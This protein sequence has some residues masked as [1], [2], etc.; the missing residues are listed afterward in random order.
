VLVAE[1]VGNDDVD[2]GS[3]NRGETG[4]I[5]TVRVEVAVRPAVSVTT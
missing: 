3:A 2:A 5:T 4:W 1:S